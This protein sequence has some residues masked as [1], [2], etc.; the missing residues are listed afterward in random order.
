MAPITRRDFHVTT[1]DGVS[2]AI[3]EVRDPDRSDRVPM[4]LLHGTRIPGLSEFD[5]PV[6]GGSLA[7]DLARKGHVCYIVDARGFG[8]S[9]RPAEMDEPP[10][11]GRRSLVRTIEITHDVDAAVGHLLETTGA[12][13][14]GLLGWGVGGTCTLMYAAIH[15]KKVSHVVLYDTIYGGWDNPDKPEPLDLATHPNYLVTSLELLESHW[16]REIPIDDKAAWRD[17]EMVKAFSQ[18]LLDGDPKSMTYDPPSYRSPSGML[19]DLYRMMRGEK[20]VHA[21]QV[22]AKV[23]IVNPEYD[24]LC[25]D[26]D[27]AV[28][29]EDLTHAEEVIHYRPR[30]TTHYLLLDRPERGRD[31][32]LARLDEFLH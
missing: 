23:M 4:I 12:P 13:R 10:V 22:Y 7:E 5:L 6:P 1:D 27:M 3:R 15:P 16:D 32:L 26:E 18:A 11:P 21:S 8:R 29:V 17:P 9:Q 2:I 20:L 19:E 31:D 25:R 24:R 14:A 30:N 28:L